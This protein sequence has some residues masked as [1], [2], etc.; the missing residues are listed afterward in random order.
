MREAPRRAERLNEIGKKVG[1]IRK[2]KKPLPV[3]PALTK[4]LKKNADAVARFKAFSPSQQREYSEW[5][6]EARTDETR[7]KRIATAVEWIGEG[8]PR[9]WKYRKKQPAKSAR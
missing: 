7:T 5:I 1:P 6:D 4:A 3:P 8:K 9:M 2:A